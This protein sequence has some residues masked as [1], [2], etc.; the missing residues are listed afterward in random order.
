[1]NDAIQQ[2]I[3]RLTIDDVAHLNGR[4]WVEQEYL[5]RLHE[6]PSIRLQLRSHFSDWDL[7]E[8]Q[9]PN[10]EVLRR[11]RFAYELGL[12]ILEGNDEDEQSD[13]ESVVAVV[14][15]SMYAQ[16]VEPSANDRHELDSEVLTEFGRTNA[17]YHVWP[18]WREHVQAVLSRLRLPPVTVPM[19]RLP[20]Q[21]WR[22][23][24]EASVLE[25]GD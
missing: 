11:Y 7:D 4:Y 15:A 5:T 22:K 16:Y 18:Y 19:F 21:N 2:V 20:E 6:E 12:R 1:M 9:S 13:E 24:S 3:G 14:E 23:S 17:L 25:S 8:L 10:N